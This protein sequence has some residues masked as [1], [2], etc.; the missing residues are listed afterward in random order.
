MSNI[1]CLF[2]TTLICMMFVIFFKNTELYLL[3]IW[4]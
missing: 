3:A 4:N 2:S 1:K